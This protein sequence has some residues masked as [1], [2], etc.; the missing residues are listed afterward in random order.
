MKALRYLDKYLRKYRL[1]LFAGI[2]ITVISR[3][4][5]LFAPRLIG[6]SLTTV[7]K[8][9]SEN[10]ATLEEVKE[11][12]LINILIIIGASILSA[13]FTFLMRQM[14]INVSRY[15]EYD[16]KNEIF[17]HYQ[18]LDQSFYKNNRTGD[19]MN[20]ISED[21]S[22]VRLYFGPAL[23][24]GINTITLFL[25]VISFMINIAPELTLYVLL[26]LPFLSYLIYKLSKIINQRSTKV[27]EMLSKLSSYTQEIFSGISVIKSFELKNR[28]NINLF[29]L[30]NLAQNKN[31]SLA[32]VQAWFFPLMILMIG[33]SNLLVIL[34]GGNLFINGKIELGVIAEFIV[35]I[36]MLTWPVM[37]VGWITSIV[38]QAEASQKRINEFLNIKSSIKDGKGVKSKLTGNISFKS[39]SLIY[40]ET[41]IKALDSI[42][43]SLE[44]GK[45]MGIVGHV[46]SGKST[47]L[48]L[49]PRL[50]DPKKGSIYIDNYPI[51]DFKI[52]ELRK[53]I[54][55][56]PQNGFL[57]SGTIEEN[58]IFGNHKKTKDDMF[59]VSKKA[60]IHD[61]II[62]F[63]NDYKTLIGERGVTLSGGQIQRL[64][65][66]RAF[67]KNPKILLLDDCLSAVDTE[68][69][70]KILRNI[71]EIRKNK[72]TIIVSHRIS[73]VKRSDKIIVLKNGKIIQS[74]THKNLIHKNGYYRNLNEK[75]KDEKQN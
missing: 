73:T 24:Y 34:I 42:S 45:T 22:K 49:I 30:S 62:I 51:K 6:N 39:V 29:S 10:Q 17:Q 7:E 48:D 58:I 12:L 43:F 67:I 72:T 41:N 15:I 74:G 19:L 25:I 61:N 38:Q 44:S 55:Y 8:F 54:G 52:N 33:I 18:I 57:F 2:I 70:E 53:H 3:I 28:I 69:E 23:M 5:S 64:T 31:M 71:K 66:A 21:V 47:L 32:K 27:Q 16:L 20:R 4:F 75:Q 68:T 56:V 40:P 63:K 65:I 60:C 26:P 1:K 46:G 36:N 13:F 59:E 14:I 11:I 35:Y 9:L 37:A 50:Y